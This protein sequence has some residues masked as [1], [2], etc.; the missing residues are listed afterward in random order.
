M[1]LDMQFGGSDD[2]DR[3]RSGRSGSQDIEMDF[4]GEDSGEVI[5]QALGSGSGGVKGRRKGETFDCEYCGKVS[6][7]SPSYPT[8][9]F[10]LVCPGLI[11]QTYRHPSCLS[12][13]RWEHSAHWK[14]PTAANMSKH[15]QVQTL[16]AA[17][18]LTLGLS[19]PRDKSLWPSVVSGGPHARRLSSSPFTRSPPSSVLAPLTPSSLREPSSLGAMSEMLGKERKSSPGSDSTTSS[20]GAG[21]PYPSANGL[22][23]RTQPPQVH[24]QQQSLHPNMGQRHPSFTQRA[25]RTPSFSNSPVHPNSLPDM[26]G[27]HFQSAGGMGSHGHGHSVSPIPNRGI[28]LSL[29]SRTGMIGG[30]MFGHTINTSI[31]SSSIRSGADDLPEEDDDDEE[32]DQEGDNQYVD[33]IHG[34]GHGHGHRE[35]S[36]SEEAEEARK[37]RGGEE[38]GM[39]EEMEL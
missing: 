28:P 5:T 35:Q 3:A 14:E 29:Q 1:E 7:N 13:H 27:L 37:A 22:G 15:Q 12:K 10:R 25:S 38:Y 23:L 20:M 16:E 24:V 11:M 19:L 4:D 30:G 18:I 31:R 8:T 21:E 2:D 34:H 36:S 9:H 26:A 6:Y 33:L 32:E 39:A 17:A